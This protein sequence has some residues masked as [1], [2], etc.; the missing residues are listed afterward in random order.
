MSDTIDAVDYA[1]L[2]CVDDCGSVWKAKAHEWINEHLDELPGMEPV[3]VQTIGRRIDDLHDAGALDTCI[4]SPDEINRDLMIA[5][6]LTD[7]G[8][9][10]M[11]AKREDILQSAVQQAAEALLSDYSGDD[12]PVERTPLI[13]L[14]SA[15]FDI[16]GT[17]RDRLERCSTQEILALLAIHYFRSNVRTTIDMGSADRIFTILEETPELRES[18]VSETIVERIRGR[19]ADTEATIRGE[20]WKRVPVSGAE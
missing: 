17:A 4:L 20:V 5:Y 8:R 19:L 3:S 12:L 13:A 15:E 16:T 6:T 14:T 18:F 11:A 2:A 1:V 10:R 9:E 7:T